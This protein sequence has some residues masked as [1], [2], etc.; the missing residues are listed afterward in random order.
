MYGPE[1]DNTHYEF[2]RHGVHDV[3]GVPFDIVDPDTAPSGNNVLVLRGGPGGDWHSN[4]VAQK[5][6]IQVGEAVRA[7]HV[8]GGVAGWGHPFGSIR[9]KPAVRWTFRY[10]DGSEE[11]TVLHDGKHFADW[12]RRHD[13]PGS[14]FVPDLLKPGGWGQVRRF[15]MRPKNPDAVV[16]SLVL[17]SFDNHIAPTFLALTAELPGATKDEAVRDA[18]P[19]HL[20]LGGGSSHDFDR[21]F[22]NEDLATLGEPPRMYTRDYSDRPNDLIAPGSSIRMLTLCTNQP[23]PEQVRETVFAIAKG[24]GGLFAMHAACWRNWEDWDAYYDLIGGAATSHEPLQ[25]FRVE[26]L[27]PNHPVTKGMPA[28]FTIVDELYRFE[29]QGEIYVLAEG[30]SLKTGERYPVVW[31]PETFRVVGTTLGHDGQAHEHAAFKT[32]LR[33]ATEFIKPW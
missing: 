3:G 23:L 2:E 33:N 8:L 10:A 21:W 7:I 6:E 20:I 11:S 5:V 26:V 29:P 15:S 24:G 16:A 31:I 19:S 30:V 9:D 17:E 14:D 28:S 22:K 13:V 27:V 32:L 18:S 25:E 1:R 4:R 12:I